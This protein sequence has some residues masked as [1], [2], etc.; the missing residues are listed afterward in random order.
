L[1]F[2][3]FERAGLKWPALFSSFCSAWR[4]LSV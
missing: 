4:L 2:L 1:L 3:V